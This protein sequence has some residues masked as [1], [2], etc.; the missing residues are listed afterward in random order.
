MF[1]HF[2][3]MRKFIS[4]TFFL[5]KIEAK[6]SKI[7]CHVSNKESLECILISQYCHLEEHKKN[8]LP[9]C[10]GHF[11]SLFLV[12]IDFGFF[13]GRPQNIPENSNKKM[14]K[15]NI[16]T[17]LFAKRDFEVNFLLAFFGWKINQ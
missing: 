14:K 2:Y 1:T 17:T 12:V 4:R 9:I 16:K 3:C 7:R 5:I 8:I 13:L 15:L 11:F 10:N 6:W